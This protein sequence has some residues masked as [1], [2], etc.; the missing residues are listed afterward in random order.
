[1]YDPVTDTLLLQFANN[2]VIDLYS[3]D[4]KSGASTV[5]P[6]DAATGKVLATMDYSASTGLVFGIGYKIVGS[7]FTR[8]VTSLNPATSKT[9][10]LSLVGLVFHWARAFISA[11]NLPSMRMT[12]FAFECKHHRIAATLTSASCRDEQK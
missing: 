6:Q 11:D 4:L 2:D 10:V 5:V 3:V 9:C 1:V 7:A 8:T 12:L